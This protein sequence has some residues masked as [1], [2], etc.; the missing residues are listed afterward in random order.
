M[1][2]TFEYKILVDTEEVDL[3]T[4]KVEE[5]S[6]TTSSGMQDIGTQIST[7]GDAAKNTSTQLNTMGTAGKASVLGLN[8]GFKTLTGGVQSFGAAL[9]ANPVFVLV[10]VILGVV[11]V[12]K[13]LL[14]E[15]GL[16]TAVTDI[17]SDAMSHLIGLLKDLTDWL[18]ITDFA[19]RERF[20]AAMEYYE[21]EAEALG[22]LVDNQEDFAKA[23]EDMVR[24]RIA[25][26]EA[27]GKEA[28][29]TALA[30]SLLTDSYERRAQVIMR[31]QQELVKEVNAAM[32]QLQIDIDFGDLSEEDIRLRQLEI[33]SLTESLAAVNLELVT[34]GLEARK[35]EEEFRNSLEKNR[36]DRIKAFEEEQA[37]RIAAA[38]IVEDIRISLL[39]DTVEK[40]LAINNVKYD[41]LIEDTL[42]NE[43]FTQEEKDK[44]IEGYESQRIQRQEEI[45]ERAAQRQVDQA[46]T[47]QDLETQLLRQRFEAIEAK[48]V[49]QYE[50]RADK[51][52][53]LIEAEYA[54]KEEKLLTQ[55]EREMITEEEFALRKVMLAEET[56]NKLVAIEEQLKEDKKRTMEEELEMR[57]QVSNAVLTSSLNLLSGVAANLEEGSKFAK[58]VAAAQAAYSTYESAVAAYKSVVGIPVVGPVMAPIAAAGA[59]AFGLAN[60]R[61][62]LSSQES[63]DTV[64]DQGG[65]ASAISVAPTSPEFNF[66][67]RGGE[68]GGDFTQF[69]PQQEKPEPIRAYVSWTDIDAVS[70]QDTKIKD[71]MQL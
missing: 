16:L 38:R 31:R 42:S 63:M 5:L 9:Q 68:T 46:L 24:A 28:E 60:V 33:D 56:A 62:I 67:G 71:E 48:T 36:K 39:E 65:A 50:A 43:R 15:L 69:E 34:L 17:L 14:D 37:N 18:G 10:T 11:A 61:K 13:T 32:S 29:A 27:Q 12:I 64:P 22:K 52:I 55:L 3:A 49:E 44:I 1:D 21:L 54:F 26:L 30:E 45:N 2:K 66:F 23:Q 7:V 53:Q 25:L 40:E 57:Q 47:L 51:E 70:K 6:N 19:N 58:G 59:V 8:S 20:E 4:Q 41:R 35:E